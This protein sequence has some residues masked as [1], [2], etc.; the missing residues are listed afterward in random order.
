M[1]APFVLCF[2]EKQSNELIEC[3]FKLLQKHENSDGTVYTFINNKSSFDEYTSRGHKLVT[4][5]TLTF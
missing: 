2:D 3:G 1:I 4:T 5:N